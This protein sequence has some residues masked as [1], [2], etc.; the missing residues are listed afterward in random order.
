MFQGI[1]HIVLFC[2]D[3]NLSKNWYEKVGFEFVR[4]YEGMFW[5]QLGGIEIMLHPSDVSNPGL[6]N[7]HVAVHNVSQVFQHVIDQGLEPV[8]HQQPGE[9]I[10]GPVT[11]PWGDIEFELA[12]PDGHLWA[13]TEIKN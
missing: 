13:F 2:K 4:G 10:T 11:R 9:K 5:F 6:T 1:H 7:L 8:D 3:T 12:D